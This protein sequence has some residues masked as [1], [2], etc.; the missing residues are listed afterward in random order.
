MVNFWQIC[1]SFSCASFNWSH[2]SMNPESMDHV[3]FF[4]SFFILGFTS[5]G[6]FPQQIC[7]QP[8][9]PQDCLHL[10]IFYADN[11]TCSTWIK[12][13]VEIMLLQFFQI[14]AFHVCMSFI[15]LSKFYGIDE[16]VQRETRFHSCYFWNFEAPLKL[17]IID[18]YNWNDC[19]I[20]N[21]II[22]VTTGEWR[23]IL[24]R[25]QDLVWKSLELL[26]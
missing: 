12:N 14:F 4:M 8:L 2:R 5:D 17:A 23:M 13:S 1:K 26:Y 9:L 22:W 24:Q 15:F 19:H 7:N 6:W 25:K 11:S 18:L 21:Y 10:S 20:K 3:A 16:T